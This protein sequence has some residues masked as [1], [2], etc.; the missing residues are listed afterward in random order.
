MRSS[1]AMRVSET[2][3]GLASTP[4][5][6]RQ[7]APPTAGPSEVDFRSRGRRSRCA[8]ACRGAAHGPPAHSSDWRLQAHR[9][10]APESAKLPTCFGGLARSYIDAPSAFRRVACAYAGTSRVR[11]SGEPMRSPGTLIE[12]QVPPGTNAQAL[13]W[14]STVDVPWHVVP[15]PAAQ[16]FMPARET[17]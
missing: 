1:V 3:R 13:P 15:G 10:D 6:D 11:G 7:E 16:S 4:V 14:K 2:S 12:T 17:P 8:S 9:R 5:P